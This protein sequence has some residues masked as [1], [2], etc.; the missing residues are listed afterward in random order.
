MQGPDTIGTAL[1]D[2]VSGAYTIL[3]LPPGTYSVVAKATGYVT[4]S[5]DN[6]VV[7]DGQAVVGIDFALLPIPFGSISG[8]VSPAASAASVFA[9]Q[10]TDTIGTASADITTGAYSIQTLPPGTYKVVA[11]AVGYQNGVVD[12]VLVGDSQAVVGIDFTL[13][14]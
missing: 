4:L 11:K 12:N 5:T 2:P 7:G 13:V 6:V 9:V 8:T 1:A 3:A 14:P 10:G